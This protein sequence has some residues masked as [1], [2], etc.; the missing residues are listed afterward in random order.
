MIM[1]L[2]TELNYNIDK[3]IEL[4]KKKHAYANPNIELIFDATEKIRAQK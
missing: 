3:A 1:H 4:V 2:I